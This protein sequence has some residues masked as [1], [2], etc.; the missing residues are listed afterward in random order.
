MSAPPIPSA[1]RD[2]QR[3]LIRKN[4]HRGVAG[5]RGFLILVGLLVLAPGGL[6]ARPFTVMV[7]NVENL[8]DVDGVAVYEEYQPSLHPP[9]HVLTKLTNI[10][11]IVARAGSDGRG[12]EVILF[13]EIEIDHTPGKAAPDYPAILKTYAGT[14]LERMLGA[15]LNAAIADLPAEALLLKALADRGLVGYTVVVGGDGDGEGEGEGG[16]GGGLARVGGAP[17]ELRGRAAIKNVVFTRFPVRAVRTYPLQSARNLLEVQLDADGWPLTVFNAHWRGGASNA[18]TEPVRVENAGV[19]R[20]RLDELLKA[21]PNADIVIGG[22]LNSHYNQ[23]RRS[24]PGTVTGINDVLG[25]Q[26]NELALRGPS[27]DLYNLWFELAECE[28]GSDVY[29]GEWGTLM[30][31]LVTRGLYDRSG[32]Q[33]V[34]NSFAVAR[35][36]G[37][38]ADAAGLPMRWS[39]VGALGRGYSD[40]FPLTAR[41]QT[42]DDRQPGKFMPLAREAAG[43]EAEGG[44]P[45]RKVDLAQ[46][47][48][49]AAVKLAELPAAADLRDG[50]WTGKLFQVDA[51]ALDDRLLRVEVRGQVYEVYGTR[52]EIRERLYAQRRESGGRLRFYG[53]LGTFKGTWQYAVKS[54]EWVR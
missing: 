53:E 48:F 33:Y 44:A 26:G 13:Q 18:N 11:A 32:V 42:V 7:Y 17:L 20:R 2:A 14:T 38:N 45:A 4:G 39:A 9:A 24:R 3:R 21:D 51:P 47:D 16:V 43:H 41:F 10:A 50:S 54:V 28:R 30:H 36:P 25:S 40:H 35:V 46:T 15:E 31:L 34:D 1:E 6:V 49:A 8:H 12:P 5:L 19:L 22:D 52:K 27:R 37:L 29:A 23:K